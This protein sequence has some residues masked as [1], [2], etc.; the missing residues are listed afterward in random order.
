M[1]LGFDDRLLFSVPPVGLF[2]L[3]LLGKD[4]KKILGYLL[5]RVRSTGALSGKV[6]ARISQVRWQ[7]VR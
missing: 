6:G 1:N 5:G 3:I 4:E 2:I 7:R